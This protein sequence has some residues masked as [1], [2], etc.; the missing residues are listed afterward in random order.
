MD[1]KRIG[2]PG[3]PEMQAGKSRSGPSNTHPAAEEPRDSVVKGAPRSTREQRIKVALTNAA[4]QGAGLLRTGTSAYVGQIIGVGLGFALV[5]GIAAPAIGGAIGAV[6]GLAL[7]RLPIG[8]KVHKVIDP[9]VSKVAAKVK[10]GM[11]HVGRDV[12]QAFKRAL[13]SIVPHR[14]AVSDSSSSADRKSITPADGKAAAT[15][16]TTAGPARTGKSVETGKGFSLLRSLRT[17]L[18]SVGK[19]FRTLP[20]VLYPSIRNATSAEKVKILET[21]DSLPLNTVTSTESIT[22]SSTLANEMSASGLAR[23]LFFIKPIDLDKGQFAIE[24]F[25]KG[26]LIHE[27]GHTYDFGKNPI[28]Y[29]GASNKA[30]WGKGPYVFDQWIDTPDDLYAATNHFEDFAQSHKFFY[31]NPDVLKSTNPAK[32]EAMKKLKQPGLY[33][34]IFDRPKIRE[35]AKKIS[36]VIDKVPGLRVALEVAGNISGPLEMRKGSKEIQKGIKDGD[37]NALRDGKLDLASGV[38]YATR[39]AAPLG[40]AVEGLQ[41]FLNRQVKKGKM[42][43]EKADRIADNTLAVMTGPVGLTTKSAVDA[44]LGDKATGKIQLEVK[45]PRVSKATAGKSLKRTLLGTGIGTAIGATAGAVAGGVFLGPL[46]AVIASSL[47]AAGAGAIGNFV[48]QATDKKAPK[49]TLNVKVDGKVRD[50]M[51][52]TRNDKI[53]MA[54]VGGGAVVGGAAGTFLG[55]KGGALAGAAAGAL[56]AGPIGAAIGGTLGAVGGALGGSFAGSKIGAAAGKALDHG[57]AKA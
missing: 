17:G 2:T 24:G 41:F 54:K 32:Y 26:T 15:G 46:G 6:A 18:G 14:S 25:G 23:D 50:D 38:A 8:E 52:L 57:P 31:E 1:I 19:A 21:L 34:V 36:E 16:S 13:D 3:L 39:T 27:L 10:D 43:P 9:V 47:G 5:G 53:Y 45:K 44:M 29:L 37:Q 12:K 42:T 51:A 40:M 22:M 11:A 49:P 28:P 30:P 35:A 48:A 33:D 7:D 20:K 56:V 4:N 55:W